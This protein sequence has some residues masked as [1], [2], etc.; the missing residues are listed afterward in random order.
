MSDASITT[1]SLFQLASYK[2]ILNCHSSLFY[3]KTNNFRKNI[4]KKFQAAVEKNI[5][6]H[7]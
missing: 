3:A 7:L 5:D 1:L 2:W 4:L 6:L